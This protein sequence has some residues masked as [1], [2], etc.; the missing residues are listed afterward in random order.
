MATAHDG[1]CRVGW[2]ASS[3]QCQSRTLIK[4]GS[5]LKNAVC[6]QPL[7]ILQCKALGISTVSYQCLLAP[8]FEIKIQGRI[9]DTALFTSVK[10]VSCKHF[11]RAVEG[12][13]A[14]AAA[15]LH[16]CHNVH[17]VAAWTLASVAL[18]EQCP[19]R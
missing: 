9:H 3:K 11:I 16:L 13:V 12:E 8:N 15:Y 1:Y 6:I 7:H 2:H 17:E 4:L 19:I 10:E 5:G 18:V 14:R